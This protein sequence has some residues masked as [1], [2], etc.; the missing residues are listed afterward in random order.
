[1]NHPK[2]IKLNQDD[3]IVSI[4][5]RN[6]IETNYPGSQ[7]M[8]GIQMESDVELTEK[9][10][11]GQMDLDRAQQIDAATSYVLGNSVQTL[12]RPDPFPK[13]L[14]SNLIAFLLGIAA[15]VFV[16]NI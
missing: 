1:M 10:N 12:E 13:L 16:Y 8:I 15:C 6:N 4:N 14:V 5:E 9:V 11:L 2:L 7:V 3:E